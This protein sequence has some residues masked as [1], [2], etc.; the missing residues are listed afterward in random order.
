MT[1]SEKRW[2]K[3]NK[4]RRTDMW[5]MVRGSVRR[6]YKAADGRLYYIYGGHYMGTYE[7]YCQ[8]D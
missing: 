6:V 4:L 8:K 3:E 1:E 7:E 5:T 2:A